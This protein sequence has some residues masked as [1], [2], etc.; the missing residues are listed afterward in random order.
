MKHYL[1]KMID[2]F[3]FLILFLSLLLMDFSEEFNIKHRVIC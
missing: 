2:G 3:I 1:R